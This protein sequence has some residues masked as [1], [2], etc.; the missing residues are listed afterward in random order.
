MRGAA[1]LLDGDIPGAGSALSR[2]RA[3]DPRNLRAG[4]LLRKLEA[5]GQ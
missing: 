2:A 4:L 1:R 5:G 3:L